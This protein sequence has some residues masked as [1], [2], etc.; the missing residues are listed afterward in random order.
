[1]VLPSPYGF[2]FDKSDKKSLFKALKEIFDKYLNFNG[3][4]LLLL[5]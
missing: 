1:L 4:K 2:N 5:D 3:K